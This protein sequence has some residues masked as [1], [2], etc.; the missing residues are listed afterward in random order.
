[1]ITKELQ[2]TLSLA[3]QFATTSRH[4][5]LTLEHLL[6]A[7]LRDSTG[8]DVIVKCGGDIDLLR[9]D[10]EQYFADKM[11]TLGVSEANVP[12]ETAAFE[13]VVQRAIMQARASAQDNV[14]AG[15]VLVSI[16]EE[17]HSYSRYLLEKQGITRLDVMNYISHGVS[18][19]E[20]E[21][22]MRM[23]EGGEGADGEGEDDEDDG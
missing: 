22:D 18:K 9:R 2:A 4:E 3:R 8:S 6:Y 10:L 17:S 1:M 12:D 11:E 5:F 16:F 19:L 15:N 23:P 20:S 13:R 14:D 7:L 21:S